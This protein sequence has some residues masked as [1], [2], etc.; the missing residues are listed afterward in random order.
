MNHFW[1]LLRVWNCKELFGSY[2]HSCRTCR[3][4]WPSSLPLCLLLRW[5]ALTTLWHKDSILKHLIWDEGLFRFESCVF[6]HLSA[7]GLHS[8][9]AMG[10]S[11]SWMSLL[12]WGCPGAS[13]RMRTGRNHHMVLLTDLSYSGWNR[14]EKTHQQTQIQH[15][16]NLREVNTVFQLNDN[17]C[18]LCSK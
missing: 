13:L 3:G 1:I 17:A 12:E 8:V 5:A 18:L 4:L 7:W 16:S 10:K 2:I 14:L 15:Y 11:H 6:V 9:W